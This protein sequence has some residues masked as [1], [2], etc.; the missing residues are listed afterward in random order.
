MQSSRGAGYLERGDEGSGG[1]VLLG[2]FDL[3]EVQLDRLGEIAQGFGDR[4]TLA[5]HIDLKALC[6]VPVLFLVYRSSEVPGSAHGAY[7][8]IVRCA[9]T[10]DVNTDHCVVITMNNL[11]LIRSISSPGTSP[12]ILSSRGLG[13]WSGRV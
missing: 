8:G 7:C 11:V 1:Q 6:H 5:G 12:M 9:R 4:A 3:V 13:T 10:T 2:V